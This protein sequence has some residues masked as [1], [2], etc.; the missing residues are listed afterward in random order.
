MSPV[1][2]RRRHRSV[3]GCIAAGTVGLICL[4]LA[5]FIVFCYAVGQTPFE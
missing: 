4:S 2:R 1:E 3:L 5:M